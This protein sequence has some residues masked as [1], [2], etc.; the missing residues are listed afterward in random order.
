MARFVQL[1]E[2][3]ERVNTIRLDSDPKEWELPRGHTLIPAEDYVAP[4][5]PVDLE[6]LQQIAVAALEAKREEAA[7]EA[8]KDDPNAPQE[9]KDYWA[10][11]E[12]KQVAEPT[13]R[14]R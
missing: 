9:V 6:R 3:G 11:R 2:R 5:P 10:A 12:P 7:L 13:V 1:D 14:T 8:A 4:E